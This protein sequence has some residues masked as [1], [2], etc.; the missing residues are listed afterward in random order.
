MNG[1]PSTKTAKNAEDQFT[2][3][4]GILYRRHIS[5]IYLQESY[6]HNQE[7]DS[8]KSPRRKNRPLPVKVSCDCIAI[9]ISVATLAVVAATAYYAGQQWST[10]D[11]TYKQIKQQTQ[12]FKDANDLTRTTFSATIGPN[13]KAQIA[14]TISPGFGRKTVQV[15]FHDQGKIAGEDFHGEVAIIG[16]SIINDKFGPV[17]RRDQ[18][19]FGGKGLSLDT[20]YTPEPFP[21]RGFSLDDRD[22]VQNSLQTI[23]IDGHATYK[24]PLTNQDDTIRF[25]SA[26]L[27]FLSMSTWKDCLE[28]ERW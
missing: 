11:L 28:A 22:K 7:R 8:K 23:I 4:E 3:S 20:D 24:N 13:I 9:L 26:Y 17:L 14:N 15:P 5:G 21:M 12:A 10:M 16:R 2:D 25:C 18:F 27:Y 6:S 19:R 1:D